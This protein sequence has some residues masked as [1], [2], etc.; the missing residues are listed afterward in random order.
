MVKIWGGCIETTFFAHIACRAKPSRGGGRPRLAYT[1]ALCDVFD[2]TAPNSTSLVIHDVWWA[3][4]RGP[5]LA[6]T[7]A[8]CHV[9]DFGPTSRLIPHLVLC[10]GRQVVGFA[11]TLAQEG[12]K[13][14]IHVNVIA[15][16]AGSRMTETIMPKEMVCLGSALKFV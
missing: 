2:S 15:P 6:Y 8:L 9:R 4:G 16:G 5:R 10:V 14:N 13:R 1:L 12:H 7:L 11:Y 3:A